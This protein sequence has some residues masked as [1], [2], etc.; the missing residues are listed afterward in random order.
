MELE[1]FSLTLFNDLLRWLGFRDCRYLSIG[2]FNMNGTYDISSS[3][4]LS[5]PCRFAP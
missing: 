5:G 1:D 4:Q 3:P 2:Q